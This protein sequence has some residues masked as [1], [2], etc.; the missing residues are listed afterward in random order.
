M[1]VG[2]PGFGRPVVLADPAKRRFDHHGRQLNHLS[3]KII[4]YTVTMV[5]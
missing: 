4:L 3:K 5:Q 1:F 2:L